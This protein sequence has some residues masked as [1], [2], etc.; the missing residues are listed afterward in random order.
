[1]NAMSSVLCKMLV[2]S[3]LNTPTYNLF[4]SRSTMEAGSSK[5]NCSTPLI[6]IPSVIWINISNIEVSPKLKL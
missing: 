4:F 2:R 5:C 3:E 6:E 1:M